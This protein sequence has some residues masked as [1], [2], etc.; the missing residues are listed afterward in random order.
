MAFRRIGVNAVECSAPY[1]FLSIY[2]FGGN[3]SARPR[4]RMAAVTASLL[5]GVALFGWAGP[6]R[7]AETTSSV[8]ITDANNDIRDG[9]TEAIVTA[10]AKYDIQSTSAS[11]KDGRITL[12]MVTAGADDLTGASLAMW[13]LFT[14]STDP[15]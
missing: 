13:N 3:M 10:P 5:A 11:D 1:R 9:V 15:N 6:A 7:A 14:N 2:F 8:S 12:D 4:R